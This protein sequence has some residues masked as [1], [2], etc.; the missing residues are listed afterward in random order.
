MQARVTVLKKNKQL[1][2][3]FGLYDKLGGDYLNS[4]SDL[5]ATLKDSAG[6]AVTGFD[7]LALAYVT[8]SQ[9]GYR[10]SVAAT[11]DPAAGTTY[12]L[13]VESTTTGI[14][15]QIPATVKVRTTE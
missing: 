2:E 3:L 8:G 9:G 6:A 7:A 1:L 11:V 13:H 5:T 15:F 4:A 10:A 14:N 12:V